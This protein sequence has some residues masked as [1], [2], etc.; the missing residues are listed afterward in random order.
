[1]FAERS[2]GAE[3]PLE[4]AVTVYNINDGQNVDIMSRSETLTQYAA[5]VATIRKYEADGLE[6]TE[7]VGAAVKDC[8]ARGILADYLEQYG[9]EVLNML[10]SEWNMDTALEVRY[11]EGRVEGRVEE[12]GKWQA[13][14]AGKD[15]ALAEQT[16]LIAAL[17]AQLNQQGSGATPAN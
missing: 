11:D 14:V 1:L 2:R 8:M 15:A 6:L 16:A 4:L 12:R 17:R 13:V 9:S 5:F 7:A 10:T 3:P